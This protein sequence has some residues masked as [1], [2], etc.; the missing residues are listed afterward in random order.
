MLWE[1]NARQSCICFSTGTLG[2]T[3][4]NLSRFLNLRS[5]SGPYPQLLPSTSSSR[6]LDNKESSCSI[7]E[8]SDPTSAHEQLCR[9]LQFLIAPITED[10]SD[11]VL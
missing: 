1:F 3:T 6:R 7:S 4:D 5:I 10:S 11:M 8:E 9:W 2:M